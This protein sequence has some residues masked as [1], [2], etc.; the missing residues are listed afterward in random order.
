MDKEH[1]DWQVNKR[2]IADVI[3]Q[4]PATFGLRNLPGKKLRL[5]ESY[6]FFSGDTLW[7]YTEI[8][9]DGKWESYAKGTVDE[10]KKEIVK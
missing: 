10:L 1:R 3:A 2:E 5:S 6:S 8:E 4:F 7:L 9:I